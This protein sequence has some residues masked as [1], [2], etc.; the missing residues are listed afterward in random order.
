MKLSTW[1]KPNGVPSKTA[2]KGFKA[3]ILLAPARQLSTGT[4]LVDPPA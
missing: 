3:G 4:L 1:A 2:W